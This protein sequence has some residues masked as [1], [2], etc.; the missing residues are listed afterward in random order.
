MLNQTQEFGHF[1]PLLLAIKTCKINLFFIKKK[2][3]G[4]KIFFDFGVSF[5]PDK[6]KDL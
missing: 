6:H 2:R 5:S 3:V 4:L 1:F